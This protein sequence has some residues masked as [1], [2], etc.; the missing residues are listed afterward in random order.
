MLLHGIVPGDTLS[1]LATADEGTRTGL[2][3]Q[4]LAVRRVSGPLWLP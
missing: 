2:C 3:Q 4:L 1:G